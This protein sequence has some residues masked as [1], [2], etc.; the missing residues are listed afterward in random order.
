VGAVL[1]VSHANSIGFTDLERLAVD[2]LVAERRR[3]AMSSGEE[4]EAA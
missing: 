3:P 1:D 2:R 4:V